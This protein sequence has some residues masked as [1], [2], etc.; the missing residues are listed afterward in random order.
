MIELLVVLAI[1][2]LLATLT[3]PQVIKYLDR[4]KTDAARVEIDNL[5]ATLDIFRLDVGRYPTQAEGLNALIRQDGAIKGWSGPYLKKKEMLL[6]PWD[7]PYRYKF[8]GE[9]GEYDLST[10]GADDAEGG[11][12]AN[13]DVVS[14]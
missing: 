9:H 3:V 4:A 2:V 7:R 12:G 1:L 5:G 13:R 11:E 8:P 14:W 6:D 10:L